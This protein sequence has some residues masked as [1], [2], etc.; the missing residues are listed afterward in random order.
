MATAALLPAPST[1]EEARHHH[2]QNHLLQA[3][4]TYR[5]T[6]LHDPQNQPALLGLSLLARQ[7]HQLEPAL[8]MAQAALAVA[9]SPA[10]Q[11]LAK[12]H[13]GHCHLALRQIEAA[14]A[15]FQAAFQ[16]PTTT[17]P[18][19]QR[20]AL[21]QA[22]L[23]LGELLSTTGNPGDAIPHFEQVLGL[24]PTLAAAHYGLGNAYALQEHYQPAAHGFTRALEHCPQSPEAHFALAFCLAKLARHPHAIALY[25]QALQLRPTFS[26]AW[27]NLGHLHRSRKDFSQ[28]R[29]NY[30]S[31]LEL[32]TLYDPSRLAEAH[33]AFTYLHLEQ[34]QLPQAWHSLHQ[35]EG[36][37]SPNDPEIPNARGILLLAEASS[38]P[39][40]L[41]MLLEQAIEA[42]TRAEAAGHK[43]APS[44]RGNA[45]LRLGRTEEALAAHQHAVEK[46]PHHPGTRYNLALTQLRL[47][48]YEHGWPNYEVRWQFRELHP[49]PRRYPQPRWQGQPVESLLIYSEQGLGD[50]LQFLRYVPLVT[51]RLSANS[52]LILEVQPPL[53]RLLQSLHPDVTTT[54]IAQGAEPP[55]FTHHIPLLSL[56]ALF[57]TT[58]ETIPNSEPEEA[59]YLCVAPTAPAPHTSHSTLHTRRVGLSW[60]GN[61][62]YPADRERST[63]LQTFLPLLELPSIQWHSLQKGPATAQLGHFPQV[64]NASEHDQDL[65]DTADTI[66]SLDLVIS[67]DT[68][69]AHLAGALGKPL[70]LLLPWQSDWRW[71]Q[72]TL[73]TPW[74]PTARLF[75]QPDPGN[76]SALI[77]QVSIALEEYRFH[78]SKTS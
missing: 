70:W 51:Q 77:E 68:A 9:N 52:R 46:D 17:E 26:A 45:L 58:L 31:A 49:T 7:S 62:N 78:F 42:F 74:Y 8:H 72:N 22:H 66:Q 40:H 65:A 30:E 39:V 41:P 38:E 23:G 67:T 1:L 57:A 18:E 24:H 6:L 43:T 20:A 60:A 36:S 21:I 69:V 11:N 53:L 32:A 64:V 50:T 4:E 2:A 44:N 28:A 54:I 10:A 37:G 55:T 27:L 71:M 13:L 14:Q 73:T 76:W 3:A 15:A 34:N 56:P 5:A 48:D 63:Q 59:G 47:G 35:A 19:V 16:D 61:P 75:R 33:I 25:R 29:Q 12:A